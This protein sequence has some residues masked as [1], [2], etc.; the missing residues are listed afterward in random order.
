MNSPQYHYYAFTVPC[1]LLLARAPIRRLQSSEMQERGCK[2]RN[3]RPLRTAHGVE[4]E[5][6]VSVLRVGA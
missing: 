1:K 5:S 4:M 3:P 6:E 2:L